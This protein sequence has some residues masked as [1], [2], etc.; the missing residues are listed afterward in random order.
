MK[1]LITWL[2]LR[3]Q[4][5]LYLKRL[6]CVTISNECLHGRSWPAVKWKRETF[7][8]VQII[9][10][11]TMFIW[12]GVRGCMHYDLTQTIVQ[13]GS[14]H[15]ALY[16]SQMETLATFSFLKKKKKINKMVKS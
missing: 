15:F 12:F 2:F 11:P 4:S 16:I 1:I 8:L 5:S 14:I 3:Y 13:E 10:R 7:A 6:I 9:S